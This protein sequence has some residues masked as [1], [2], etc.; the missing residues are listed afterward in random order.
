MLAGAKKNNNNSN[1]NDNNNNYYN[2]NNNNNNNN[3]KWEEESMRYK[4]AT[5]DHVPVPEDIRS[6]AEWER[7]SVQEH[8]PVRALIFKPEAYHSES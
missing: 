5:G 3:P 7:D 4:R 1:E 8:I 2:N 6:I